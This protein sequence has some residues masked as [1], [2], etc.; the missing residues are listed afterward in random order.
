[1]PHSPTVTE[2][3]LEAAHRVSHLPAECAEHLCEVAKLSEKS[4]QKGC[5]MA[6]FAPKLPGHSLIEIYLLRGVFAF[7]SA[8]HTRDARARA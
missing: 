4:A 6:I 2:N 5:P 3:D 1:M 7:L 8:L